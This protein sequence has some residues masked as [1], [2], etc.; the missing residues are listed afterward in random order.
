MVRSLSTQPTIPLLDRMNMQ[1]QRW[2]SIPL[3]TRCPSSGPHVRGS[4]VGLL[5]K[6][7]L[8]I[9]VR[10]ERDCLKRRHRFEPPQNVPK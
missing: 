1:Q 10:G 8:V 5:V 2:L 9:V 4:N 7:E 6:V 3:S